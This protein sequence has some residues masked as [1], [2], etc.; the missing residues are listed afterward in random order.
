[1]SFL[2]KMKKLPYMIGWTQETF[3]D[4]GKLNFKWIVIGNKCGKLSKNIIEKIFVKRV[5][6]L[7]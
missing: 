2:G 5:Q 6:N 4:G 3:V 7:V 1:M